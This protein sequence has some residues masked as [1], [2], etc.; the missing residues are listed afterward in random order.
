MIKIFENYSI[1]SLNTFRDNYYTRYFVKSNSPDAIAKFL[2]QH[3]ELPYLIIGGGSNLLFTKDF[4]GIIISPDFCEKQII[5]EDEKMVLFQVGASLNFDK[6]IEY[7]VAKNWGGLENLSLIPGT[8]GAAPVQN[9]GAYGVEAKDCIF[10]V[11]AFDLQ[12]KAERVFTPEECHFGYRNSLF[13]QYAGQFLITAVTFLLTKGKHN[14]HI[15]YDK[16]NENI[17]NK[18][19]SLQYIRKIV[20]DIRRSKLPDPNLYPNAGSFFKNP[21]VPNSIFEKLSATYPSMPHFKQNGLY[22]IPAAWLIDKAGFKNRKYGRVGVFKNQPLVICKFS[23]ETT[24]SEIAAF[25]RVIQ[26]TVKEKF[27]IQLE[28]EVTVF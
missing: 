9:V 14:F 19:L 10:Q 12:E 20:I 26:T 18:P 23:A 17:G 8:V 1:A 7:A 3:A 16:I 25:S 28:T 22:K 15:D 24:G 21:V 13:K 5:L 2:G 27:G 4:H 11:T 6:I